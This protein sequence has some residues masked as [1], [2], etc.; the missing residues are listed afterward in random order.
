TCLH[1]FS[2]RGE[3]W[4]ELTS[5]VPGQWRWLTPDI[6]AT[7]P[8]EAV[9]AI[10][11][12]WAEA[13]VERSHL[14]GYSAGGRLALRLAV[15][16]PERLH[17][18]TLIS[19]HAG[20]EGQARTTRL[21]ADEALAARIESQGIDWFAGYWPSQP[22]FAGLRR[23]RPDL[24]ARLDADRRSRDPRLLAASLRGLGGASSPPL[25]DKLPDLRVPTMILAGAEDPHYVEHARR[26]AHLLPCSRS[27]IV[28]ES[29][30]VVHLENP[31]A[32]ATLLAAH[33]S[34]R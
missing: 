6:E 13:G 23:R 15:R 10:L 4:Q 11:Q 29:G 24:A 33:L 31:Q 21:E 32:A 30:H 19:A 14:V 28:P 1:G 16:H 7:T 34:S 2:Q 8:E 17:T 20:F 27:H 22:I 26:L 9:S 5:L 3:S 25:W 12:L 18:L